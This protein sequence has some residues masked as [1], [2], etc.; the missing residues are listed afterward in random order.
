MRQTSNTLAIV[1]PVLNEE[2]SI[3]HSIQ[4]FSKLNDTFELVFIDGNSSD[5][6]VELL[7]QNNFTVIKVQQANR[8][9][10]VIQGALHSTGDILL[11]HHFDS[12]LPN[13]F[14]ESIEHA[15][16][17]HDWGRFDVRLDSNDWRI[18]IVETAMNL[19]SRLTG[20]ATG[21]QAM[22]MRKKALL[23]HAKELE[24]YPIM[25]DIYLSKQLKQNTFPACLR[26]KVVSSARY[27]Q[28][29]G[30]IFSV[31][32]MWAFRLMYFF[33]IAPQTLYRLY[34][35]KQSRHA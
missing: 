2:Q 10:Q 30:V 11:I 18:R 1:V 29:N 35:R 19:R 12:R 3:N 20:I 23:A 31:L 25:E 27:W 14:W 13:N 4:Y 5:G 21:D 22:F 6:T 8:G 9:A 26:A 32:K 28:K 16:E 15:M 33:G 24:K 7:I 34:Y 17:L